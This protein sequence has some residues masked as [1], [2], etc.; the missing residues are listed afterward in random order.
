MELRNCL[1]LQVSVP[2]VLMLGKLTKQVFSANQLQ[3]AMKNMLFSRDTG[4]GWLLVILEIL[5]LEPQKEN[6]NLS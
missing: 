5:K 3:S 6:C 4:Y 2:H 1:V